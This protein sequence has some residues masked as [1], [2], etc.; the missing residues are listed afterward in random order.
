MDTTGVKPLNGYG[1]KPVPAGP[2]PMIPGGYGRNVIQG[3]AL[4]LV[5]QRRQ[6]QAL[7]AANK[8]RTMELR[9]PASAPNSLATTPKT[10]L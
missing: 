9:N 5:R 8:K 7:E 10:L 3:T 1:P 2:N 4:R 6:K